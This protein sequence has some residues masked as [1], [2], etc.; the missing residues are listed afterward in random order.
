[1]NNTHALDYFGPFSEEIVYKISNINIC[2][3]FNRCNTKELFWVLDMLF[4]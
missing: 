4:N 2:L 3:I 1:M